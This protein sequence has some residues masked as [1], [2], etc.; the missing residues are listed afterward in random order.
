[1]KKT[2]RK[3]DKH[4]LKNPQNSVK[5]PFRITR[6]EKRETYIF[7]GTENENHKW[8]KKYKTKI[9]KKTKEKEKEYKKEKGEKSRKNL[10][11]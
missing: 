3:L 1:M 6:K 9:F 4:K 5:K 11:K 10:G 2:K 7:K 8:N